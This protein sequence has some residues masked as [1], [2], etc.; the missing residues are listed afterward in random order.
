MVIFGVTSTTV[1]VGAAVVPGAAVTVGGISVVDDIGA[2]VVEVAVV[3]VAP[4]LAKAIGARTER[5]LNDLRC[6][7]CNYKLLFIGRH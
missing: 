7:T 4:Q 3:A 2:T 5:I 6:A 1:V